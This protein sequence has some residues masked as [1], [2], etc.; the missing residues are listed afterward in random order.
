MNKE[1]VIKS[2][3]AL[4]RDAGER[5]ALASAFLEKFNAKGLSPD[6]AG[7]IE[8]FTKEV[9]RHFKKENILFEALK[10]KGGFSVDVAAALDESIRGH[11]VLIREFWH[12]E[13]IAEKINNGSEELMYGF[14]KDCTRVIGVLTAHAQVEDEIL[15]PE[16]TTRLSDADFRSL[17]R[18]LSLII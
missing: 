6:I 16:L 8:F 4:H 1:Q 11:D 7:V 12:L 5:T 3:C 14:I 10:K 2:L 15:F 13:E 18:A 17:E 9:V